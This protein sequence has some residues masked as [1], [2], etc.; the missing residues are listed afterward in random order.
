MIARRVVAALGLAQLISWGATY[1]LI[2]GFGERISAD[3]GWGRDIVY[4]GFA[5]ALL[6][7]GVTSPLAG[8]WVDRSGGR[9]V[10]VAGAVINALGCAGLAVSYQIG[11]YFASW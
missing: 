1:Y 3:R 5:A 6:V 10:M 8:R 9:Q 2:G 11:A 7:M 4:G